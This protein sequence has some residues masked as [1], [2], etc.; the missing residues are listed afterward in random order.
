MVSL[1]ASPLE[2]A[3]KHWFGEYLILWNPPRKRM[4]FERGNRGEDVLMLREQLKTALNIRN[5]NN[6]NAFDLALEDMVIEFQ[7]RHSLKA[8]GVAGKETII[9]LNTLTNK[10]GTPLLTTAAR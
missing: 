4:R 6:S 2:E 7:Q 1:Q 9:L 3:D 5:A 8:D 10:P